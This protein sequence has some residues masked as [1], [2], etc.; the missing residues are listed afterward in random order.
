MTLRINERPNATKGSNGKIGHRV[1][2][3][4]ERAGLRQGSMTPEAFYEEVRTVIERRVVEGLEPDEWLNPAE[5]C[6]PEFWGSLNKRG[7]KK[8]ERIIVHLA[9]GEIVP[10]EVSACCTCGGYIFRLK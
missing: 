4:A 6:G 2:N 5:V 8:V 1:G 3:D 7:R 9:V 10:F